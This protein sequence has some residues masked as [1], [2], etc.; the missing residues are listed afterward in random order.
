MVRPVIRPVVILM[1]LLVV[2]LLIVRATRSTSVR[3][4]IS[5]AGVNRRRSVLHQVHRLLLRRPVSVF[6]VTPR[7]RPIFCFPVSSRCLRISTR[8][9]ERRIKLRFVVVKHR[10]S[11]RQ[12]L[13]LLVVVVVT[14]LC[15][16]VSVV[17]SL[18]LL[19]SARDFAM[20]EIR[21]SRG[22]ERAF[23]FVWFLEF[24]LLLV[25]F[26]CGEPFCFSAPKTRKTFC[27]VEWNDYRD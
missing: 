21:A 25:F 13:L 24:F 4:S 5:S 10:S 12:I 1:V 9:L 6:N 11:R 26:L 18:F 16:M 14:A 19:K 15:S 7:S 17:K 27:E 22:E 3:V 23:L 20:K 2:I 8:V